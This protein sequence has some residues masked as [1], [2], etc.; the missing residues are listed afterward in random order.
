SEIKIGYLHAPPSKI[1]ISLTDIPPADE[2]LAGAELAVEDNTTT[3]QFLGQRFVLVGRELDP[4]DDAAAAIQGLSDQGV[5]LVVTSI[6]SNDLL[7]AAD[8]A[9]SRGILLFNAAA[10][11]DAL[12]EDQCRANIIHIVPSRSMLSDALAQY[13]VWKKWRRWALIVGSHDSDRLFG[14]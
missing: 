8:A 3:G 13:L 2:G 4:G 11:D 10:P 6:G 7:A 5:M 12:R 14:D 1:R 9:R